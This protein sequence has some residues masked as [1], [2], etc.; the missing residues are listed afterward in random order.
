M[1][2]L[3]AKVKFFARGVW[4]DKHLS[5]WITMIMIM[6]HIGLGTSIIAGGRIRFAQPSYNPLV[7]FTFGYT[8]IWGVAICI[9]AFLMA[10]PFR[11][12]NIAGL[13]LG[14]A[15]HYVWMAA[16][17]IA[18]LHYETAAATPIPAYGG[19]A[20]ICAALLTARVIDK[21]EG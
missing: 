3:V 18:V 4:V 21:S 17:M 2:T 13:L 8:W 1:N 19:F 10:A 14:M 12:L 15:W 6:V 9:S 11:W 7:D 20:M 16:F 5:Q